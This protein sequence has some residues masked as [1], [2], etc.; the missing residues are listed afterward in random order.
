VL[1]CQYVSQ[2]VR[3]I[4][5]ISQTFHILD[6]NNFWIDKQ[7]ANLGWSRCYPIHRN[8]LRVYTYH[9][10][11]GRDNGLSVTVKTRELL[12]IAMFTVYWL[13][14]ALR[15]RDYIL[16]TFYIEIK[17]DSGSQ[18]SIFRK[19]LHIYIVSQFCSRAH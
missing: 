4:N 17:A 16:R 1:L 19:R 6:F 13:Y 9:V 12:L 11:D 15:I 5:N 3:L 10:F 2:I 18:I 14:Y 8:L 7:S